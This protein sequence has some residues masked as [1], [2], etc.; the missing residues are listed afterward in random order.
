MMKEN[1][2]KCTDLYEKMFEILH[3]IRKKFI[4]DSKI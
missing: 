4:I 2:I 3:I 1:N